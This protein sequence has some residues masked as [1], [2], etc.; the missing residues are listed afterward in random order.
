MKSKKRL[1]VI[2]IFQFEDERWGFAVWSNGYVLARNPSQGFSSKRALIASL[3]RLSVAFTVG[4]RIKEIP[5]ARMT[6]STRL[7][8][9]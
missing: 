6:R 1:P 8:I 7:Q 9:T 5:L 3:D 4:H 2:T